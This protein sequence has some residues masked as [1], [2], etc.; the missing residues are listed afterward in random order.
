MIFCNASKKLQNFAFYLQINKMWI[1]LCPQTLFMDKNMNL[2]WHNKIILVLFLL[3]FPCA[4]QAAEKPKIVASFSIIGDMVH[5]IAGDNVTLTVLVGANG[6][7][8]E[9]Q[10][11]AADAKKISGADIV[12]V[13][14]LG[15]EGWLERLVKSVSYNGKIVTVSDGVTPI[16]LSGV[17]QDPHAWQ[18]V[19]NGKIY[20]Q[21]IANAL[22]AIDKP[23]A[24][25]YQENA[26]K[27]NKKL[28]A[29][30]SWI[31]AEFAKIPAANRRIVSTHDAFGYFAK[32]YGVEFIALQG[33]STE[34]QPTAADMAR[35]IDQIRVKNTAE[36]NTTKISA[37]FLENMTD[38]RLINQLGKD[39]GTKIGGTLYS[40]ALSAENEPAPNYIAMFKHNVSEL[41]KAMK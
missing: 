16:M 8:H 37:M 40:D 10:P 23:N 26:A 1:Y 12:F 35:I 20:V 25:K 39:T 18:N 29:L 34:S 11:T 30:N 22:A 41:T 4:T 33:I 6:D 31:K 24:L 13:N 3:F 14:G 21:N 9:Y 28:D 17:V 5:E 7:A 27:Y 19:E 15:F 38:S 2:K 36:N 32:A